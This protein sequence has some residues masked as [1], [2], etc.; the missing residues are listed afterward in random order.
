M[1]ETRSS[2]LS[3]RFLAD[4]ASVWLV[5]I[6][7]LAFALRL[8][9]V[10][11]IRSGPFFA[12]PVLDSLFHTDWARAVAA[13][14]T[15]IEGP[16]F[17]APLYPWFLGLCFKLFGES[18]LVPRLIQAG[19]GTVSTGLCYL[20]GR[21]AFN[22]KTGLLAALFWAT[23]W[24]AIYFDGEL[25]IPTLLVPLTLLA[26]WVTLTLARRPSLKR[27]A[28]AGMLW[29]LAAIARPSV[30]LFLPFL[31]AWLLLRQRPVW[32]RGFLAA[33]AL[34][35]GTLLPIVPIST[36]NFFV[37]GDAVLISS[38]AGVNF[39]IG[40]NPLSD[41]TSAVFP[42]ARQNWRFYLDAIALAEKEEGRSLRASEV[43]RHYSSKAWRF[44]F[45]QPRESLRHM[46]WKLRLFWIDWELGNNLPI[47]FY[48][49]HFGPVTRWLP[50]GFAFLAPMGIL[51]LLLSWR[52]GTPRFPLW[53]FLIVYTAGVVLFFVCSRFR[54]PVLPVLAVYGAHAAIEL[55]SFLRARRFAALVASAAVLIPMVLLVRAVP[56]SVDTSEAPGL[57]MLASRQI[58]SGNYAAA[59]E[60]LTRALTLQPNFV[61]GQRDLGYT[62]FKLGQLEK[63]ELHL[64]EADRLQP[65]EPQVLDKLSEIYLRQ[66]RPAE[67]LETALLTTRL[68]PGFPRGFYNLGHAYLQEGQRGEAEGAFAEALRL[69]PRCASCGMA[70]SQLAS[71]D[72]RLTDAERYF[73]LTIG[74][75]EERGPDQLFWQA[76]LGLVRV[77]IADSRPAEARAFVNELRVRY[78]RAPE[79]EKLWQSLHS[80]E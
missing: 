66:G 23:N 67:A 43:S 60:L 34:T 59:A 36:Y 1:P 8:V 18:F 54:V 51:G 49:F 65:N 40:N 6:L 70:L 15:F 26:L 72:G 73:R 33:A 27:T 56:A 29:G 7:A 61:N 25:L 44:I 38:Q 77:L 76:C 30:L 57:H 12:E 62:L 16:F 35:L 19:F 79:V 28:L 47:R 9:Y 46:L 58:Y 24:V 14:E 22:R 78:P 4:P 75:G 39:W 13:G 31:A 55:L 71:Q 11:Q 41:G 48:A 64:R 80:E 53:G 52:D 10:L 2:K 20:L 5:L 21:E 63:A 32:K 74:I 42:G 68:A 50:L 45:G 17:R 3:A 69:D 37:G